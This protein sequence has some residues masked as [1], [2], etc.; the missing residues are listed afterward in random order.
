MSAPVDVLAVLLAGVEELRQLAHD[1]ET[2]EVADNLDSMQWQLRDL[3]DAARLA[4]K[5]AALDLP[6][7]HD[8]KM[9]LA[10][11]LHAIGEAP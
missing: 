9:K 5:E 1:D 2:T 6:L 11:A 8:A 4:Y 3:I 10:H 7:S